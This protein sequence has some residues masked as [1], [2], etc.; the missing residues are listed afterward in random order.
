M[1]GWHHQL[2]GHGF[3]QTLGVGDTQAGLECCGSWGHKG[4]DTTEQLNRT[5]LTTRIYN[6]NCHKY[7]IIGIEEQ[8]KFQE[9][10]RESRKYA[11]LLLFKR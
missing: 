11:F 8:E 10:S 3:G 5:E 7:C 1:V 9:N 4:S 2:G 6:K